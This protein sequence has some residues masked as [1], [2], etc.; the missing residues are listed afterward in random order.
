MNNTIGLTQFVF[1][2]LCMMALN[3]IVKVTHAPSDFASFLAYRG[4][5]LFI[6]PVIWLIFDALSAVWGRGIFRKDVSR[7]IGVLLAASILVVYGY[8]IFNP[9]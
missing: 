7:V 5:W 1:L 3:I 4:W 2:S 9:Q 8:A 6:I